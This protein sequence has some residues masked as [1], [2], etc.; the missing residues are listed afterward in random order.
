MGEASTAEAAAAAA[1]AVP[2][3]AAIFAEEFLFL[4]KIAALGGRQCQC[5]SL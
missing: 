2:G 5:G 4:P 3:T 1:A